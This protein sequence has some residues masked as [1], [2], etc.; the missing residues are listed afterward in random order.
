M[1][2]SVLPS[3]LAP[4]TVL[5]KRFRIEE[6]IGS[7]GY[8]CVY[9][10][11]DLNLGYERAI[12]EV[13]DPDAH[14]RRQFQLEAELL[15]N[16]THPNV[17][18]G[19]HLIE[20]RGRMYFVMEFIRGKDLEELL[21]ESLTQ[22]GRPLD[23]GQVLP[24]MLDICDAL[25]ELHTL[26]VPIIHRDL[27]PANIKITPEGRPVLIDFGLAK[28]QKRDGR[29]TQT[30][31]QGVSPGFAPP[32]Q[33]MAK[34]RTDARTDIYGLGATLYAAVEGVPPFGLD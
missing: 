13:A 4:G 28:L 16:T 29:P 27:K 15:I 33:Y 25:G 17:P 32:E 1:P 8:A 9:R 2:Q 34:G 30:A 7:G 14:V 18:H 11:T 20:D 23:E 19:Y 12:K 3:A 21:N 31:A 26:A 6:V 22:R 24:W 10:A 5:A